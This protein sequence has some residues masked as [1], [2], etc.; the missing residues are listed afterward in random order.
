MS[1]NRPKKRATSGGF[2][3]RWLDITTTDDPVRV[4]RGRLLNVVL[5]AALGVTLVWL[6]VSSGL[7]LF[8]MRG[9]PSQGVGLS[10]GSLGF[11]AVI[12]AATY[13]LNRRSASPAAGVLLS[14]V[15][16]AGSLVGL[17]VRG[18]LTTTVIGLTLPVLVAALFGPPASGFVIATL[19]GTAYAW[20]NMQQNP[21]YLA[22]LGDVRSQWDTLVVYLNLYLIAALGWMFSRMA[23][24]AIRETQAHL[25][26]LARQFGLLQDRL[27]RQTLRM[28]ATGGVA[29]SLAGT[30]ELDEVLRE[31]VRLVREYFVYDAVLL[32]LLDEAGQVA[33]LRERVGGTGRERLSQGH[34]IPIGSVSLVGRAAERGEPVVEGRGGTLSEVAIPLNVRGEDIGVL[35]LQGTGEM[36]MEEEDLPALQALADQVAVA[37]ANARLYEEAQRNL[38]QLRELSHEATQRSWRAYLEDKETAERAYRHGSSDAKEVAFQRSVVQKVLETGQMASARAR[39]DGT[40]GYLAL[41]MMLRNEVIGVVGVETDEARQWSDDDITILESVAER[42]TLAIEN[43]RLIDQAQ[44][45]AQR[46]QLISTISSRLQRAPTLQSLLEG[47][48]EELGK[49]LGTDQVYAEFTLGG[50]DDGEAGPRPS[51]SSNGGEPGKKVDMTPQG[52]DGLRRDTP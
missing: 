50:A 17:A 48:A 22:E 26:A 41:P 45:T 6:L 4:R 46:E 28:R 42:T 11:V 29:R 31:S 23:G 27:E 15:A 51:V 25:E 37:I 39:G 1:D 40:P 18:L 20:L 47:V 21:A 32:Y 10:I 33:V 8:S 35:H 19:A 24:Q 36:G 14:L 5:L 13:V 7:A 44:H 52:D 12:L 30:R 2:V 9:A 3:S 43:V 49:A 34:R 38:R 16:L